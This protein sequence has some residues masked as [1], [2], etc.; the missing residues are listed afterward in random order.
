[1]LVKSQLFLN[2]INTSLSYEYILGIKR[3][4]KFEYSPKIYGGY[5]WLLKGKKVYFFRLEAIAIHRGIIYGK[6]IIIII[7]YDMPKI[8][9]YA[10]LDMA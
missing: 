6:Y 5:L 10:I 2:F 9:N 7:I 4:H 8:T 3:L 1:M